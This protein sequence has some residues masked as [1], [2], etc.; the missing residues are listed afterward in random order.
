MHASEGRGILATI[1]HVAVLTLLLGVLDN[2]DI[3][4]I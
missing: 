3:F 4:R 1:Q 2:V